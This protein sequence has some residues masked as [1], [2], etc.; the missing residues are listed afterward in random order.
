M[1]ALEYSSWIDSLYRRAQELISQE[2]ELFMIAGKQLAELFSD[3]YAKNPYQDKCVDE[4]PRQGMSSQ[5]LLLF[6][7]CSARNAAV[8]QNSAIDLSPLDFGPTHRKSIRILKA[9]Q[10]ILAILLAADPDANDYITADICELALLQFES[11]EPQTFGRK[12]VPWNWKE[13]DQYLC[14]GTR[15]HTCPTPEA[16]FTLESALKL[17]E[18][19]VVSIENDVKAQKT[20]SNDAKKA[21]WFTSV[22]K[23]L[24][25]G[26]TLRKAVTRKALINS[27]QSTP[28]GE[29]THSVNEVCEA[30][31]Q[32]E[33][34]IRK[35]IELEQ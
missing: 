19:R 13:E 12:W 22:T 33:S 34:R 16:L 23:G 25:T 27:T 20:I 8:A 1:N 6:R 29:W 35:A 17:V 26:D 15:C 5:Q 10:A 4:L 14:P 18:Q 3:E 28:N 9:R 32:H 31:P 2:T 11:T 24:L 7:I 30:Y 21:R